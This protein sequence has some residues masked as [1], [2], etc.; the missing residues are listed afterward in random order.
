M[1]VIFRIQRP[2]GSVPSPSVAITAHR[3]R[4]QAARIHRRRSRTTAS[5]TRRIATTRSKVQPLL[6]ARRRA[7]HPSDCEHVIG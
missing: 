7:R 5:V 6:Q 2:E 4:H 1:F 3:P